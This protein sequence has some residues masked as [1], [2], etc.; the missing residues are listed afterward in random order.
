M[1]STAV[2]HVSSRVEIRAELADRRRRN[3]DPEGPQVPGEPGGADARRPVRKSQSASSVSPGNVLSEK[4]HIRLEHSRA[5]KAGRNQKRSV[6]GHIDQRIPVPA[7]QPPGGMAAQDEG[8]PAAHQVGK[9][10]NG[11]TLSAVFHLATSNCQH[12]QG[13][14]IAER[15]K[16]LVSAIYSQTYNRYARPLV[17]TATADSILEL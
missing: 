7:G 1:A 16:E 13:R 8:L 9:G 10:F 15:V 12:R 14:S 2:H 5:A 11:E 4:R 17:W 3:R 6:L